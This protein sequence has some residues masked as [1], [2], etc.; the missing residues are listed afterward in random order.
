MVIH[1]LSPTLAPTH[2]FCA[3]P[4]DAHKPTLPLARGSH[5][6]ALRRQLHVSFHPPTFFPPRGRP[7]PPGAPVGSAPS[8]H[9]PSPASPLPSPYSTEVPLAPP[10]FYS[11]SPSPDAPIFRKRRM[12]LGRSLHSSMQINING[13]FRLGRMFRVLNTISGGL[14][15]P[16]RMF[17]V[18]NS[19]SGGLYVQRGC[20]VF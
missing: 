5:G 11:H 18:Q 10:S 9:P 15:R 12:Y 2:L 7:Y 6:C 14:F 17:R 3:P 4:C 13:L 8:A 16:V 20:F 19:I 1:P